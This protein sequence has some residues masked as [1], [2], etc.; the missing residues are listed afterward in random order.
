L[1]AD[2]SAR[3]PDVLLARETWQV[4]VDLACRAADAEAAT[5]I[6]DELA[7]QLGAARQA[8]LLPAWAPG[9]PG[10]RTEHRL[11]HHTYGLWYHHAL[12]AEAG[13]EAGAREVG[14]IRQG[15]YGPFDAR[16]LDVLASIRSRWID[17]TSPLGQQLAERMGVAR[18]DDGAAL[19]SG[20]TAGSYDT[21]GVDV[22]VFGLTFRRPEIGL[23]AFID[24][25]CAERCA[26]VRY[27][28]KV[29]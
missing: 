18:P 28:L 16:A 14:K 21:Q 24:W 7:V 23:P 13:D 1:K 19:A 25:L 22:G 12:L 8:T 10:A 4:R 3:T 26:D 11:A 17:P 5:A 27:R 2:A 6:D 9:T 29:E 15:I 20:A